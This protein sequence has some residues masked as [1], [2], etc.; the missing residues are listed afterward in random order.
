MSRPRLTG[1]VVGYPDG[2]QLALLPFGERALRHFVYLERPE[3]ADVHDA[4]GFD[5]S[6]RVL[7][8]V[9]PNE[10]VPGPQEF[11]SVSH[12]D[13][14]I[15]AGSPRSPAPSAKRGCSSARPVPRPRRPPS[16]GRTSCPS[17]TSARR[18]R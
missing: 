2:V 3:G 5:H 9:G 17:R 4:E 18:S 10:L 14:S 8:P 13:R 12:L 1:G 15:E 11:G 6:G 7:R 16:V